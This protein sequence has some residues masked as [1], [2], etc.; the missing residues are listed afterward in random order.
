VT[1]RRGR[2]AGGERCV[3]ALSRRGFLV[4]GSVATGALL[5][6][7]GVAPAARLGESADF[8]S[9]P[10]EVALNGWVKITA[11][12]RITV[13]A[14]RAEMGQGVHTALALLV[15]EELEADWAR[16]QVQPT[17][18]GALYSNTA[19]LLNASP[20]DMDDEGWGARTTA[21]ALQWAGQ[22][23]SLH[24]TG[25]S[26]SV[27]DAWGP[28]RLAG[29]TAKALLLQSAAQRWQV[30]LADCRA[31]G[32][33]VR[34]GATGRVLDYGDLA[35]A[36]ARLKPPAEVVLKDPARFRLIGREGVS[37]LDAGASVAGRTVYGADVRLPG[38]CFAAIHHAPTLGGG[39]VSF[40]AASTL[41]RPGVRA[42]FALEDQ[43]AVAVVADSFWRAHSAL[44][45]ALAA[46]AVVWRDGPHAALSTPAL[47][48]QLRTALQGTDTGFGFRSQGDAQAAMAAA[49][50]PPVEAVYE[51]PFLAHAALEPVNC[52]AQV[53][54][55]RVTLW[56]PTQ[57]PIL[58]R[59]QA[60][61]TARVWPSRVTLHMTALGGGFGRR[62]EVDMVEEAVAIAQRLPGVPV[63][64]Q[65]TREEDFR[66]DR[67][68]PAAM[69]SFRAALD[70][71]GRPQAWVN[72]VAAPSVTQSFSDRLAGL[73]TPAVPDKFQAEGAFDLPYEIP[74][75]SV[76]QLLVKTPVPVGYWRSVGHSYN[77]FFTECFLDE[78]AAAA[79][80]DPLVYRRVLLERHP[81]H[82]A[83]LDLA[84]E[85][86]GWGIPLAAGRA[87]G[88]ALHASF[89]S[90][91]AQVAEVSL[92]DGQPRVHR[93]VCAVDCGVV[94]HPTSAR[95]QMEGAVAF[96]LTAAL[97]GEITFKDGHIEQFRFDQQ[98][99]LR[100]AQMPSVETHFFPSARPP[101]GLGEVGVPPIAP[102]VV[103]ALAVLTG[104]RIRRLPIRLNSDTSPGTAV[105]G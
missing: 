41:Q 21:A 25:G 92:Q 24:A 91:C 68:R 33:R 102:A 54:D 15:A 53:A 72:R 47:R 18:V 76:R 56:C 66:H 51:V 4:A 75:L 9:A 5:V 97:M 1:V 105:R 10:G 90:I 34:H 19:L 100:L 96:G 55:G 85:K 6:G 11:D 17:P 37:R 35:E 26:S 57:V 60:A 32:G 22:A 101:G 46:G 69:A 45:A 8:P 95:A 98:D 36:A 89:G 14:P 50:G 39:V 12:G 58:A 7:C 79:G 13:A 88:L 74:H 31:E 67:F 2:A 63:Q 82:R 42:A 65:W 52:T 27:R 103:N 20:F 70:A 16:V 78:L 38:L 30:P 62:L 59:L 48:E 28:L 43:A 104:Q 81:R 49:T 44:Q 73:S 77:A 83:V 3:P 87:R 94:V 99:V 40:D 71:R 84:A 64:L 29:A 86:A 23:L 61:R 93:V 80:Q